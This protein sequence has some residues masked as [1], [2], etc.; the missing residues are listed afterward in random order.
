MRTVSKILLITAG[1]MW[2]LSY[3][4]LGDVLKGV[5][6]P[7][8]SIMVVVAF[9]ANFFPDREYQV[10]DEDHRLRDNLLEGKS[11]EEASDPNAPVGTRF[12]HAR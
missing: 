12:E 2:V 6:N 11:L 9:I 4:Y 3:T 1:V 7:L 10:F 8:A 5:F